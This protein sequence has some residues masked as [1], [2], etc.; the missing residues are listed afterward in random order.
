MRAGGKPL[1]VGRVIVNHPHS[2]HAG[3]M[4]WSLAIAYHAI[5]SFRSTEHPSPFIHWCL[6][7][8]TDLTSIPFTWLHSS[9]SQ[10]S[11]LVLVLSSGRRRPLW[12]GIEW[13]WTSHTGIRKRKWFAGEE[14]LTLLRQSSQLH[15]QRK[16]WQGQRYQHYAAA[17]AAR[18]RE[19]EGAVAVVTV[20]ITVAEVFDICGIIDI[21]F[22]C[23][24]YDRQRVHWLL[25]DE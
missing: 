23:E 14:L 8:P 25:L 10:L 6:C 2:E 18:G 21:V 1:L 12:K 3:M 7:R 13:D 22:V 11:F 16:C 5:L 24:Y 9:Q 15:S 20:T 17:A 19:V 4:F